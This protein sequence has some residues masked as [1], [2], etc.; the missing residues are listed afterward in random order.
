MEVITDFLVIG[1]GLGGLSFALKAAELGSVT[2]LTKR[3]LNESSTNHAQGGIAAVMD[4]EDSFAAHFEDTVTAGCYINDEQIVRTVVHEGP[5]R[6]R[7]LID[8]GVQFTQRKNSKEYDLTREGGHSARRILHAGDITG[9]EI[10]RA[11]SES[12]LAHPNITILENHMAIDLIT[13][14]KFIAAERDPRC[15][16]AYVLNVA[17]NEIVTVLAK[18]TLLATGGSGK[19]Y[20][21]TSNPDVATGD[22]IAMAFRARARIANMEFIQFHPTCLYHPDAKSYLISEA[23]RGEGGILKDKRGRAFMKDYHPLKDLAPRDIVA[24]AIDNEM[25]KSGEDCVYLDVTHLDHSFIRERFPNIIAKCISFGIDPISTP[26]PVVPA[27]HYTCGGVVADQWAQTDLSGLFAVGEVTSTG[28]HGANRLA[29]NSLLEAVVFSDRAIKKAAELLPNIPAPPKGV[30]PPWDPGNAVVPDE[31]IM[32][33]HNWDELRR[34]M[35]NFVSIVRSNRRLMRARHRIDVLQQEI[36]EFYWDFKPSVDL[37]ELRNITQVASLIVACAHKRKESRGLHFNI[38]YPE[39][40]DIH[41]K[42]DSLIVPYK[43]TY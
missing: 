3:E 37:L 38:D 6:I 42:R 33:S 34:L 16:G 27:A 8:W 11:L 19:V 40:D 28:L 39:T 14:S 36:K 35:W 21:Y 41:W 13:S 23:V 24:R 18:T 30:I 5:A 4:D 2:V 31:M 25:K 26:I 32:V 9:R 10:Q 12:A 22:G 17:T 7:E 43:N 1:G 15:L 29:S 20:L